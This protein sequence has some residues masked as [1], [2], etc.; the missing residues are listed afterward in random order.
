MMNK[1]IAG[2]LFMM[3]AW[4]DGREVLI[5]SMAAL[6]AEAEARAREPKKRGRPLGSKNKVKKRRG[7]PLGSKDKKPRGIPS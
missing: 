2:R 3:A 6:M 4:L 5:M 1:W 7:R